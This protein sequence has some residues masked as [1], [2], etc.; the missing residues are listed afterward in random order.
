[1][2]VEGV[3]ELLMRG[4]GVTFAVAPC[5]WPASK[6]PPPQLLQACR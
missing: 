6:G 4:G 1:M 3:V 5:P 2:R